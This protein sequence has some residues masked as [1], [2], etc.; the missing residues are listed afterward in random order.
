MRNLNKVIQ[1]GVHVHI[2]TRSKMDFNFCKWQSANVDGLQGLGKLGALQ[3]AIDVASML[4]RVEK[5]CGGH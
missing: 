1:T 3:N 4:L 2:E 5:C